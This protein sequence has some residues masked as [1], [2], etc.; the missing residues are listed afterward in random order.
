MF[1][2]G[3]TT[4][5]QRRLAQHN[6]GLV[7]STQSKRPMALVHWETFPSIQ[8]AKRREWTLKRNPTM[9]RMF[10]KR[11]ANCAAATTV[12]REMVG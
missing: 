4:N 6:S 11:M 9:L 7:E 12:A 10:K 2:T 3:W 1:Y 5:V 8:A